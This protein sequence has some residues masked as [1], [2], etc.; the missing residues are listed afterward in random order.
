MVFF[1]CGWSFWFFFLFLSVTYILYPIC[2]CWHVNKKKA[3]AWYLVLST[4][5][6]VDYSPLSALSCLFP[7][8]LPLIKLWVR[9][10]SSSAGF[11]LSE[12]ETYNHDCG[13]FFW[14]RNIDPRVNNIMTVFPTVGGRQ[15]SK[16]MV[17]WNFFG[18]LNCNADY[19]HLSYL[20]RLLTFELCDGIWS[21]V[22]CGIVKSKK[23]IVCLLPKKKFFF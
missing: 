19:G 5:F 17:L 9:G 11:G 16:S 4:L 7:T 21:F 22:T 13:F 10:R 6:I 3:I 14:R 2:D 12:R 18:P 1:F 23:K 20:V 8:C 15:R